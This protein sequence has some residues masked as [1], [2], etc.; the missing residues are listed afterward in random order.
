MRLAFIIGSRR[1]KKT[2]RFVESY[3]CRIVGYW[4]DLFV[5]LFASM[6]QCS[7]GPQRSVVGPLLLSRRDEYVGVKG[8]N[9][10]ACDD[11]LT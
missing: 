8:L 10:N 9:L 6:K 1:K 2:N 7:K 4:S 11:D 5:F 3:A